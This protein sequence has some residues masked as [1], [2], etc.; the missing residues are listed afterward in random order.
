MLQMDERSSIEHDF[1]KTPNIYS[2]RNADISND[3]QLR[4]NKINEIKDYLIAEIRD[5]EL[6]SK[7]ILLLLLLSI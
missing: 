3:Q 4:L 6:L 2:N 7:N 5:R 1:H